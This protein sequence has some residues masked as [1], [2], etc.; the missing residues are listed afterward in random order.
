[1]GSS[2]PFP[3]GIEIRF[4]SLNFQATRN[5]YLMRLTNWDELH[6]WR[7]TRPGSMPATT[8]TDAPAPAQAA[9][10]STSTS[11]HRRCLGQCSRQAHVERRRAACAAIRGDLP[12]PTGTATSPVGEHAM[13][14][15]QFPYGM[16]NAATTY[17]SSNSTN[18]VSSP[19][20]SPESHRYHQR[21]VVSWLD[22]RAATSD[23]TGLYRVGILRRI[24]PRDVPM[25][26]RHRGLLV[27]LFR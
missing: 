1:M 19:I 7:S 15:S 21:R 8:A 11:R 10:A 26:P 13:T 4:G 5:D 14:G 24:G 23:L 2:D 17:T 6:P 12:P 27:Q 25:I 3:P 22:Q 20:S 18:V 16:R 9:S